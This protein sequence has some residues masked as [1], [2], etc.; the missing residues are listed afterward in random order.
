M[1]TMTWQLR[2]CYLFTYD[3]S[4]C[5]S[6]DSTCLLLIGPRHP[7]LTDS[8][9]RSY[10]THLRSPRL[11]LVYVAGLYYTTWH[12]D[13]GVLKSCCWVACSPRLDF[14]RCTT[15]PEA[16]RLQIPTPLVSDSELFFIMSL[17]TLK[18]NYFSS[19]TI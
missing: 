18:V 17:V 13:V 11:I 9:L 7:L 19:V 14:F 15:V 5:R 2:G 1:W 6:H 8:Y 3:S 10:L 16:N 12:L 4:R